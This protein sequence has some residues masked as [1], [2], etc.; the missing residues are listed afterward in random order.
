MLRGYTLIRLGY[1]YYSHKKHSGLCTSCA[2]QLNTY[3]VQCAHLAARAASQL[4]LV[5][6][7]DSVQLFYSPSCCQTNTLLLLLPLLLQLRGQ[8]CLSLGLFGLN[9]LAELPHGLLELLPTDA[10]P[11]LLGSSAARAA[12]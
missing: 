1:L 8:G 5:A 7:E 11:L 2:Q 6:A 4:W 9:T 3:T 10:L 12:S